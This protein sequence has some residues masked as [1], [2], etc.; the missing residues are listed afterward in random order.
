MK[1]LSY[2]TII[3]KKDIKAIKKIRVSRYYANYKGL[4]DETQTYGLRRIV[5]PQIC[6]KPLKMK[7]KN[8]II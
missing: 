4:G 3:L 1:F 5:N 7:G 2:H 8:F 6:T